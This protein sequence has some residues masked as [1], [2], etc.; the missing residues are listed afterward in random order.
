MD[1]LSDE[2]WLPA[3]R[4]HI[5][6]PGDVLAIRIGLEMLIGM[7]GRYPPEAMLIEVKSTAGGPYERFGPLDRQVLLEA[8][9]R[10]GASAWLYWWPPRKDLQRIPSSEWPEPKLEDKGLPHEGDLTPL[11]PGL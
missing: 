7:V 10:H 5:P 1:V 9:E 8:A 11:G 3:S 4:R 2:G 6:G